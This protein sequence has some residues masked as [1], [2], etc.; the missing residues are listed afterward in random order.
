MNTNQTQLLYAALSERI[1]CLDGA[2]GSMIFSFGLDEQAV[3]GERFAEHGKELK[4][5]TDIFN[6]THPNIITD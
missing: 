3:R 4:N 5:C 6:L 2:M 1:L